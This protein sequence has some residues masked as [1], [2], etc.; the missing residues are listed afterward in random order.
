MKT[1]E[2]METKYGAFSGVAQFDS[3]ADGQLRSCMLQE[4]NVIET[5]IGRFIPQY[6]EDESGDR[7]KKHRCSLSF[8]PNGEIRSAAL[9]TTTF[10]RHTHQFATFPVEVNLTSGCGGCAESAEGCAN[11]DGSCGENCAANRG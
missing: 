6:G 10:D 2:I 3:Y 7:Q 4:E 9:K 8:H 11:C 5:R 1:L